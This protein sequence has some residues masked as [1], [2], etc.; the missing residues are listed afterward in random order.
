MLFCDKNAYFHDT[1]SVMAG[2]H[3]GNVGSMTIILT[4]VFSFTVHKIL[5]NIH[6]FD[7]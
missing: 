5:V 3:S 7:I 2:I 4:P 6:A 1:F